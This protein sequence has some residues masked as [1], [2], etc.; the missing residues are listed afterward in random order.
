LICPAIGCQSL[1]PS[2][3]KQAHDSP[4][5][6]SNIEDNID[7]SNNKKRGAKPEQKIEKK[8]RASYGRGGNSTF[9]LEFQV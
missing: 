1:A 2:L 7:Q 4:L 5:R 6:E 3:I 9:C 8:K